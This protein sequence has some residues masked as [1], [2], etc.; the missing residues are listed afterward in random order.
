[1]QVSFKQQFMDK[2][3]LV[4][5]LF[6][7]NMELG[8][9]KSKLDQVLNKNKELEEAL[10]AAQKKSGLPVRILQENRPPGTITVPEKSDELVFNRPKVPRV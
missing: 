3:S 9:T 7:A 10:A 2:G 5:E 6:R 1:M 8:S 4:D